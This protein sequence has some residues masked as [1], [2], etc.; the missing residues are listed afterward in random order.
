MEVKAAGRGRRAEA[1]GSCRWEQSP[2]RAQGSK[3]R[4][5]ALG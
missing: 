2:V 3:A 1:L 5:G 4:A